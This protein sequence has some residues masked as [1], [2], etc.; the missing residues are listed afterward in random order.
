MLINVLILSLKC[1][2]LVCFTTVVLRPT[3]AV[4]NVKVGCPI[5]TYLNSK[6]MADAGLYL[7][8]SCS[9]FRKLTRC[10]IAN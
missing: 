5:T 1:S 2:T 10:S 8:W 4:V 7:T 6:K 9:S 3:E